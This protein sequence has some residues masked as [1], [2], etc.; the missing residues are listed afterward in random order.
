MELNLYIIKGGE[1]SGKT[2]TCWKL[3]NKLKPLIECYHYWK[4]D[5]ADSV[6]LDKTSN[7]YVKPNDKDNLIPVDFVTVIR[8]A[9]PSNCKVAIISAGD[10]E[11]YLKEQIFK[12]LDKDIEHIVCCERLRGTDGST[13][14]LLNTKFKEFIK[15]TEPLK[16]SQD[17][18]EEERVADKLYDILSKL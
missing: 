14:K 8:L 16:K 2:T 11:P 7:I 4:T 6:I 3:L 13:N 10:E 12:M 9:N 1:N 17:T 15:I 18:A 5:W